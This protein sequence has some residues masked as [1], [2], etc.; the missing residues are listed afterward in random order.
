MAQLQIQLTSEPVAQVC[1]LNC[2]VWNYWEDCLEHSQ[3]PI[4]PNVPADFEL[5]KV[6][7]S[8]LAMAR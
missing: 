8:I 2:L 7:V 1:F 5:Y 6:K 3:M 4:N